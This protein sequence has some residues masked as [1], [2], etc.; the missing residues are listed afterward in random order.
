MSIGALWSSMRS[1]LREMPVVLA[2]MLVGATVMGVLGG[3]VGLVIGYAVNPAT[4]LFALME[5]GLLAAILG[6]FLG[7]VV[8]SIVRLVRGPRQS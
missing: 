6:W 7:L 8:G 1:D 5:V 3:A 2:W 4:A